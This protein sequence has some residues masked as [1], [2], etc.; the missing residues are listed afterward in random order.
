MRYSDAPRSIRA[1]EQRIR[2]REGDEGLA[3]RCRREMA[4][5]VIGQMLPEGTVKGGS[6]MALR[7][8]RD[9]RFTRDLDVARVRSLAEFRS[10]FEQ[11]L[12]AGWS[13]FTGRLVERPSPRPLGVPA[14]YVMR[15]FD[16]KLAYRGRSWC[17]VTFE[18]GHNEIGD[19]EATEYLLSFE[20]AELFVEVG[21]PRPAPVPVMRVDHQ[22]AQKLHAASSPRSERARDIVDL[23][24]LARNENLDLSRVRE[25]CVR[26]FAY[27]R[28]QVWPPSLV[29]GANWSTLYASAAEDVDVIK[30]VAEAVDWANEFIGHIEG[31]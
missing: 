29:V 23:Q 26:L 20:I 1:L 24:L 14:G 16:I 28:Q 9:A 27:R 11:T 15:P 6:A 12:A 25:T 5:A 17:T 8:G 30:D 18:L 2:N 13:G 10:D 22:I 19:A 4:L 21:L 7:Y 3:L 31:R